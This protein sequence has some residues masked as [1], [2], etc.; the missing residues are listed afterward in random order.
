MLLHI[1]IYI[2]F[3][4]IWK[5]LYLHNNVVD[6]NMDKFDEESDKSHYTESNSSRH[7]DLL[8]LFTIG[9]SAFFDETN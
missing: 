4:K 1:Y 2:D 5:R 3:I 8:E 9:L 6:R 7:S